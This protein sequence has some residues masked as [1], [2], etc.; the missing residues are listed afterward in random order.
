[1]NPLLLCLI[2]FLN[3]AVHR[4]LN[5]WPVDMNAR[6]ICWTI[7]KPL[8]FITPLDVSLQKKDQ[9]RVIFYDSRDLN[10]AKSKI[11]K[12]YIRAKFEIVIR[13][14]DGQ[15]DRHFESH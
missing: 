5:V 15:L 14:F 1:M 2:K 8:K 7:K 4:A 13:L 6:K 9:R 3:V 12:E 11:S 10:I